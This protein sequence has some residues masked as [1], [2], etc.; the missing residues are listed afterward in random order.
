MARNAR[1]LGA[2]EGGGRQGARCKVD[3]LSKTANSWTARPHTLGGSKRAIELE[4]ASHALGRLVEGCQVIGF[5]G[6]CLYANDSALSQLRVPRNGLLRRGIAECLPGLEGS[7]LLESLKACMVDRCEQRIECE[8]RCGDG[9][10]RWLN[11]RLFPIPSGVCVL[12]LD[13]SKQK[14]AETALQ[15]SEEQLRRAQKMDAVGKLAGGL[16]HDL[17]NILT[18]VSCHTEL[19]L[20]E[21]GADN[22]LRD[23]IVE[24]QDAG[25]R[26]GNLTRQLLAFSRQQVVRPELLDLNRCVAAMEKMLG[27]M[28]GEQVELTFI[29]SPGLGSVR[30]DRSQVEQVLAN[31]V[32]NARDAMPEGGKLTIETHNV[33]LDGQYAC[34]HLGV[35]PGD[36]VM[37]AVSD[38]GTGM[39]AETQ[40]RVFEPFFTTKLLG[41]G[42]GLGLSTVF[43][44]VK[45]SEGHI[46]VHSEPGRGTTFK[47]YFPRIRTGAPATL[48]PAPSADCGRGAETILVVEDDE[49]VRA[50][51]E[52][53]LRQ[54]GYKVLTA[55]NAGEALLA[56]EKERSSI[57][58]LLT[59]VVL[60]KMGGRQLAERLTAEHSGLRVLYMSG[61]A[62]HA[63]EHHELVAPNASCLPKPLTPVTLARRVR[64]VLD[65]DGAHEAGR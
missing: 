30:A 8:V 17:N 13:T 34:G 32:V 64:E 31:L 18:V 1:C 56:W 53:T 20:A 55:S 26:A 35:E 46:R 29:P 22:P 39:D 48:V 58:L 16:A 65:G 19:M 63:I 47:F 9:T 36:Y 4:L 54:L 43:G 49:H 62:A 11:F 33:R 24:I 41:E 12:S 3:W 42:T 5:D 23:D 7:A 6:T 51:V 40:A 10:R 25:R 44:I 50:T 52:R 2:P 21:V 61:F 38:T 15:A 45:Q 60:P 57:H 28:I 59:D 14:Q 27:R 37:C